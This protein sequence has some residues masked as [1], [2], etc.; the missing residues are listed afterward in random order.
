MAEVA[1]SLQEAEEGPW[2]T[3][4][5]VKQAVTL[6]MELHDRERELTSSLLLSLY[7]NI[8]TEDQMQKGFSRVIE[9]LPDTVI[10]VPA[11]TDYVGKFLARAI[12]DEILP[13]SFLMKHQ[14]DDKNIK[15]ALSIAKG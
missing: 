13:P 3:Y 1:I 10:D 5:F 15:E 2:S 14:D 7:G 11:A 6:A 4:E 9:R 12:H 8:V